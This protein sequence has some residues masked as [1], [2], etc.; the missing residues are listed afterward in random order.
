MS[1]WVERTLEQLATIRVSNVDKKTEVTELPVHLCNYMDVYAGLYLDDQVEYME[2]SATSREIAGFSLQV[3]DVVIT[4]DSESPDDI[5]IPAL[6]EKIGYNLICGYHLAMLRPDQTK[7]DP[8]FLLKQID[9][10]SVRRYFSRRAAGSTRYALSMGTIAA[11]PI[12]VAPITH[13]TVIARILRTLDTEIEATG[14]LIAKQERLRVGLMQALFT[15]GVDEHGSL[16]PPREEATDLYHQ[17]VLGWVPR[18]WEVSTIEKCLKN[19]ID[20]RGVPPP[21]APH[22]VPLITAKN[23]RLGYL[24]PEPREYIS[25][26]DFDR[27]MRRGMP[28]AG[29]V[30][31]TTEAPLAN[32]AYVP[33][34]KIAL[35]QRTLTLQANPEILMGRYLKWSLMAE[36]MRA[37]VNRLQSGSTATGI[38]QRTFRKIPIEFPQLDEQRAIVEKLDAADAYSDSLKA[39]KKKLLDQKSGLVQ[40]LLTGAVS[41]DSLLEGAMA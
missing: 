14:A 24:D 20:Y 18:G 1:E 9:T 5:G 10:D 25:E 35:G 32:V 12:K 30:L 29:D 15:R 31:F 21:K 39:T 4:K 3:G 27:W 28:Q 38:Q 33:D 2:A 8:L 22:G 34:Y 37:R 40:D 17:T 7:V 41:V 26:A 16:R 11:T 13:Q 23:V 6:I 36:S 19:I